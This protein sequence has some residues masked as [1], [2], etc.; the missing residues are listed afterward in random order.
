LT[1]IIN[2]KESLEIDINILHQAMLLHHDVSTET[3]VTL[4][5]AEFSVDATDYPASNAL[6]GSLAQTDSSG[7]GITWTADI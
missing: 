2:Q 4:I 5:N 7:T 3:S 6:T 1:I